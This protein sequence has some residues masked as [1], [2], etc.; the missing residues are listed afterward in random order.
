[1][2]KSKSKY[3]INIQKAYK[4]TIEDE[5]GNTAEF[6]SKYGDVETAE[7]YKDCD[8]KE[9]A[10]ASAKE[11]VRMLEAKDKKENEDNCDIA[12]C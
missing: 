5:N 7:Y 8:K 2:A 10:L 11:F 6:K 3:T 1:M 9:E 12:V 4:I